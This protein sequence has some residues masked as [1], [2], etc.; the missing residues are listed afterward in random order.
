MRCV[1]LAFDVSRELNS[2]SLNYDFI[3]DENNNPLIVEISYT[4]KASGYDAC[5]GYWDKE[6]NWHQGKFNP[7]GWMV[8]MMK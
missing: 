3:F 4:N 2:S 5:D 1:K 7:Y 6:L 8:E